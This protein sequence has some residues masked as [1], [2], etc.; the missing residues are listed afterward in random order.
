MKY[1]LLS[2]VLIS[3]VLA[4]T[5]LPP[6]EALEAPREMVFACPSTFKSEYLLVAQ[7]NFASWAILFNENKKVAIYINLLI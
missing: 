6:G 7:L 3:P 1:E 4:K 2:G 5:V